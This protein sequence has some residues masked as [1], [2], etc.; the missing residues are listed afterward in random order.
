MK[1]KSINADIFGQKFALEP[2]SPVVVITGGNAKGKTTLLRVPELA[3][4][5]GGRTP[6]VRVGKKPQDFVAEMV[7]EA[8][9]KDAAV[10]R[11]VRKGKHTL[12][13]KGEPINV[14]KGQGVLD[15][16]LGEAFA[17]EPKKMLAMTAA[18]QLKWLQDNVLGAGTEDL[19][20]KLA[21]YKKR[22]G[23]L[24]ITIPDTVNA[25][26]LRALVKEIMGAHKDH[27]RDVKRLAGEVEHGAPSDDAPDGDPDALAAKLTELATEIEDVQRQRGAADG[28]KDAVAKLQASIQ[29]RET[30]IQQAEGADP[31]A[32]VTKWEHATNEAQQLQADAEEAAT[33]ALAECEEA[34]RAMEVAKK[35]AQK[36]SEASMRARAK[37]TEIEREAAVDI[38][39]ATQAK[40]LADNAA[41]EL[42]Q[43]RTDLDTI[44][45]DVDVEALDNTLL[46]LR[47]ER[48]TTQ[49]SITAIETHADARAVHRGHVDDHKRAIAMRTMAHELGKELGPK[50]LL[51]EALASTFGELVTAINETL[52]PVIGCE[53]WM[54]SS[55]GFAW[56]IVKDGKRIPI[57]T[58]SESEQMATFA[59]FAIAV[60]N[61]LGGWRF[62]AIDGIEVMEATRRTAFVE[63]MVAACEAGLL[64]GCW[65]A[66]VTNVIKVLEDG[67]ELLD[68]TPPAG[69]HHVQMGGES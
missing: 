9:G 7:L 30:A 52:T 48:T 36:A 16:T 13:I 21:D 47:T 68:W 41:S 23:K 55:D 2:T 14:D 25:D 19:A 1:I 29:E 58:A 5:E 22:L 45:S 34:R 49:A 65:L 43:L 62:L 61:K 31:D 64:D 35:K 33:T 53:V 37:A 11:E 12:A 20:P 4:R 59:D 69:C 17:F 32:V 40:E 27:D 44:D 46:G 51:G 54:D 28:A 38:Q 6:F 10:R 39:A 66:S 67:S 42:Q 56:G 18:A 3:V 26:G 24:Y 60:R 63:S 8:N 50:G 15:A 57:H